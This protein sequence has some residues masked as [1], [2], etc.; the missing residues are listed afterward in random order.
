MDIVCP[1]SWSEDPA[2]VDAENCDDCGL[3][4]H[5]TRIIWGEGNPKASIMIILDNPGAREDREGSPYVCGTR[6]ALQ[7]AAYTVGFQEEDL[8]ITYILKRRPVKAYDKL[9]TR[10]ICM[11]HLHQQID[12]ISPQLIFCLGNVAVSSY[13]GDADAE[14]KS[15]R[16]KWSSPRGIKTAVSYHPLAVRRRPNLMSYFVEDWTFLRT[17]YLNYAGK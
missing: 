13:F 1:Y 16:Q 15:L 4:Q 6:Q 11:K 12:T 3:L 2:P 7:Q 9:R 8:Y 14:V 17:A 10:E 5:R